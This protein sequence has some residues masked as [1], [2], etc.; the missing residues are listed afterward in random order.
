[1]LDDSNTKELTDVAA[2]AL[3]EAPR[4]ARP[5]EEVVL[6]VEAMVDRRPGKIEKGVWQGATTAG[7]HRA[8]AAGETEPEEGNP[9]SQAGMLEPVPTGGQGERSVDGGRLHVA[10]D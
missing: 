6:Q 3:R 1:V 9:A 4:G 8:G 10:T 7:R 2:M 5:E